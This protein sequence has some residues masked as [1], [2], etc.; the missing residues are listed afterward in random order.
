MSDMPCDASTSLSEAEAE[1]HDRIARAAYLR[2]EA[3]G[4]AVDL[5]LE[6]WL[7][8]EREIDALSCEKANSSSA[9]LGDSASKA[10]TDG[11]GKP[12]KSPLPM[13]RGRRGIAA[14]PGV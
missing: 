5:H 6:D 7:E 13:S 14:A 10:S 2:A 4:F 1:R 8:A 11:A 12:K 3:R 9:V